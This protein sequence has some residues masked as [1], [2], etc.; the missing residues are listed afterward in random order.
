MFE[1]SDLVQA[2]AQAYGERM[3]LEQTLAAIE[4][5]DD[6]LQPVLK[7]LASLFAISCI[8]DDLGWIVSEGLLSPAKGVKVGEIARKLCKD[9]APNALAL[10]EAFGIPEHML[11]SPIAGDW[12]GYNA[13]D[14]Q[15][16][17][18]RPRE[19]LVSVVK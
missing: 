1:E 13:Y 4:K 11:F 3:V 16:E 6:S 5:V 19:A 10:T 12:V 17:L 9:I 2:A 15:G 18:L 14:N 8:E 7:P